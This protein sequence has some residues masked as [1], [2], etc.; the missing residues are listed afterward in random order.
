[1]ALIKETFPDDAHSALAIASCE[2]GLNPYVESKPNTNGTRDGGLFQINDTHN[3][4]MEQL[5]L[6]KFDPED[7]AKFA[8]ILYEEQGWAPWT[9]KKALAYR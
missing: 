9:C 8:R 1:M 5:G 3:A 7:N 2:S 4:R 6:D